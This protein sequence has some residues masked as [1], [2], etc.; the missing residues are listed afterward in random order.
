MLMKRIST[1]LVTLALL[2]IG[3]NRA[4]SA[5]ITMPYSYNATTNAE[6]TVTENSTL[7]YPEALGVRTKW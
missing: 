4:W 6:V 3:T 5:T 7:T 1:L 2:L